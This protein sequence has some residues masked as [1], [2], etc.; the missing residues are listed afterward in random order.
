[1]DISRD[2]LTT[3]FRDFP[4]HELMDRLQAGTLTPLA[5]EVATAELRSRGIELS[6]AVEPESPDAP[7]EPDMMVPEGDFVTVA[8]FW[9]PVEAN[10]LRT[11]L[12]SAGVYVHLWGEHLGIAHTFLSVASGGTKVQVPENQVEQAQE[13]IAAFKRGELA[14]E[15][16]AE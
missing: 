16:E 6:P 14:L 9:D 15:E 1:V 10:L 4:D 2:E 12:E 5:M 8:E 7:H 11:L 3:R 13:I